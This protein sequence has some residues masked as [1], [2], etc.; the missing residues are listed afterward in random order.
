MY[1]YMHNSS[2]LS[3]IINVEH[4]FV[5]DFMHAQCSGACTVKCKTPHTQ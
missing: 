4:K 1:M 3:Q 2:V 5:S